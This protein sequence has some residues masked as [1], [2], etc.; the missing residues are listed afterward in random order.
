MSKPSAP[1]RK[2]RCS[3]PTVVP[4]TSTV[5][6]VGLDAHA[7]EVRVV[8]GGARGAAPTPRSRARRRSPARSRSSRPGRPGPG[9]RRSA[10]RRS[11][12]ACRTRRAA[13]ARRRRSG[14]GDPRASAAA[15]RPSFAAS[16]MYG[17]STSRSAGSTTGMFTAV[18][19][20]LALERRRDL[21]GDDQPRPILRFARRAREVRS[22]DDLVE[23][24]EGPGV[25]LLPEDVERGAGDLAGR[26][27]PPRARPRRRARHVPR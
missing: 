1:A 21:L 15:S 4:E 10:R 3:G 2:S 12:A 24:E 23:L 16:G 20:E 6:A 11:A 25:R 18:S 22:H 5:L 8:A 14:A 27:S 17:P 13:R 19:H 9:R 7:H 26:G